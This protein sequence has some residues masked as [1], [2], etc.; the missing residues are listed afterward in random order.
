MEVFAARDEPLYDVVHRAGNEE[1]F[2]QQPESRPAAT[3][4][5]G[6]STFEIVS[7][8]IFCSTAFI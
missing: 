8:S 5:D 4:S 6:Y 7:D 2:L 1:I 3:A